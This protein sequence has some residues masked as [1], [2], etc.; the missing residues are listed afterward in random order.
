MGGSDRWKASFE[1]GSNRLVI[2]CNGV[3]PIPKRRI[4]K[5]TI[6]LLVNEITGQVEDLYNRINLEF[7][8]PDSHWEI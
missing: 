1:P 4:D 6:T 8:L 5:I 3:S 2:L 7:R